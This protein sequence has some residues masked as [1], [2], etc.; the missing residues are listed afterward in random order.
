MTRF[1]I[2]IFL[3]QLLF[4]HPNTP[5]R[6]DILHRRLS[7]CS[8][9]G[10]W[11]HSWTVLQ[12][13][14][15]TSLKHSPHL[16]YWSGPSPDTH[17]YDILFLPMHIPSGPSQATWGPFIL[18]GAVGDL[19][20]Q[21]VRCLPSQELTPL[22]RA[23]LRRPH[24]EMVSVL[25]KAK[26]KS[27]AGEGEVNSALMVGRTVELCLQGCGGLANGETGWNS[28]SIPV[29]S[30]KRQPE[31][32]HTFLTLQDPNVKV[33]PACTLD[34]SGPPQAIALGQDALVVEKIKLIWL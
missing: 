6:Y 15:S 10:R 23:Q 14:A 20:M 29:H 28:K 3:K 33:L 11:L 1:L 7:V 27:L 21:R 13:R 17:I 25:R 4:Q 19:R 31:Q 30:Q 5:V 34:H 22:K 32:D 24:G 12:L 9:R 18:Q 26:D 8:F 16:L 2:P